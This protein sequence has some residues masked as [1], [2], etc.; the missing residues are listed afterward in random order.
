MLQKKYPAGM[1]ICCDIS[2]ETGSVK[3]GCQGTVIGIDKNNGQIMMYWDNGSFRSLT[4][5]KDGFHTLLSEQEAEVSAEKR[6]HTKLL[7][8]ATDI[9]IRA[10][11]GETSF[12]IDELLEEKD[13]RRELIDTL[14]EMVRSFPGVENAAVHDIGIPFQNTLDITATVPDEDQSESQDEIEQQDM[15]M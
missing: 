1:R 7:N 5:G 8:V 14:S 15:S 13:F 9:A 4:P 6:L 10:E 3:A 11:E 12:D 2:Q